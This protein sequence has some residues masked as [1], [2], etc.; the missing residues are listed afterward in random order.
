MI[1]GKP[2]KSSI[3]RTLRPA[4]SSACAVPP[5]DT[6]SI[7]RAS[8][9]LAKSTMPVL[10][11][12]ESTARRIRTSPGCVTGAD[13]RSGS[14]EHAPW[15]GGVDA[16][17]VAGD[18]TDRL[19]QQLVLDRA[20]RVADRLG[21]RGRR[22]VDRAL[23]DDRAGVDALVDEVDGDAED[24]DAVGDRLLDGADAG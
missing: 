12:T 6:S 13:D 17:G 24:L 22:E 4:A 3:A 2:V 8:S 1:A 9:P 20:Q 7:P 10:S 19:A 21:L 23:Q 15:V 16:D 18:Q 11:D 5:V 14:N